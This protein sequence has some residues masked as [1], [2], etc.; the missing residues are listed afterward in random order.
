MA[1]TFL[2]NSCLPSMAAN[3]RS[4]PRPPTR[5]A[6]DLWDISTRILH[7]EK[8]VTDPYGAVS[9]PIYQT[10]TFN[11]PSATEGGPYDYSRSGNPTRDLLEEQIA[12]L[13]GGCRGLAFSSGMTA[14]VAACQLVE[15]G[16]GIVSGDDLYGG[17][18]RLL[19][20]IVPKQ[21][22]DVTYVDTLDLKAVEEV[23]KKGNISLVMLESPTNPRMQ[24]CDIR[25]ISKM[26]HDAGA[27][28]LVDNSIMASVFAQPLSLGADICMTS[29]TKF[30]AGHSD[31]TGGMLTVRDPELGKR[32]YF[33]QNAM[34]LHLGPFDCWLAMRGLKTM[35]LRVERQAENC[36]KLAAFLSSHPLVK[37]VNYPGMP[38]HPGHE[39]HFRQANSGGSLLSFTTGSLEASKIIVEETKLFSITVSF[40][41][42]VS[43]ISLP[44]F[45]SHASVSAELREARGLPDDLVRISVGIEA[46]DDLLADLK[47]AMTKA[48]A[49]LAAAGN[50]SDVLA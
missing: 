45:M 48:S 16:Q 19:Q 6:R 1:N 23:L 50:G 27:L 13:D 5:C 9:S 49:V 29:T 41:S 44:C 26:A 14:L 34:G 18:S 20:H 36:S 42:V 7:P 38:D 4:T 32:L 46:I 25:A 17:T 33:I 11:Q 37:K 22:I 35:A 40:G 31:V 24:I 39:V 21:G 12:Q 30:I 2:F 8:S 43:L 47:Q 15:A 3:S 28:V 10:A